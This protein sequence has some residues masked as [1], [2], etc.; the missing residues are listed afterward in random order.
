MS[1]A[2]MVVVSFVEV[3]V[4]SVSNRLADQTGS[5]PKPM[6]STPLSSAPSE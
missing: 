1:S 2:A 4:R 5:K 6:A 3:L